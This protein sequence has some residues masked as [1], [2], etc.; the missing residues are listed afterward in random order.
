MTDECAVGQTCQ[1]GLCADTGGSAGAKCVVDAECEGCLVCDGGQC[2][3][4]TPGHTAKAGCATCQPGT[5]DCSCNAGTCNFGYACDTEAN[6]CTFC[7]LGQQIASCPAAGSCDPD[8]PKPMFS[9]TGQCGL[10][11]GACQHTGEDALTAPL[12]VPSLGTCNCALLPGW[13]LSSNQLRTCDEDG[14]GWISDSAALETWKNPGNVAAANCKSA[15][16][17]VGAVDLIAEDG[18]AQQI[19][20]TAVVP[21][22]QISEYIATFVLK[23]VDLNGIPDG[24]LPLVEPNELDQSNKVSAKLP[25]FPDGSPTSTRKAYKAELNPLVKYCVGGEAD[26]NF[27]GAKDATEDE[28]QLRLGSTAAQTVWNR[29]SYFGQL[30]MGRFIEET[31]SPHIKGRWEVRER[32]RDLPASDPAR[33]TVGY[34]PDTASDHWKRCR[35]LTD[36]KYKTWKDTTPVG[37]DFAGAAT[38]SCTPDGQGSYTWGQDLDPSN[39]STW[40]PDTMCRHMGH[41]A[42]FRC[43]LLTTTGAA[44]GT[45]AGLVRRTAAQLAADGWTPNLCT[46]G[47]DSI[48]D[49]VHQASPKVTCTPKTESEATTLAT[50]AGR[51]VWAALPPTRDPGGYVSGCIDECQDWVRADTGLD[52]VVAKTEGEGGGTEGGPAPLL[53]CPL[54]PTEFGLAHCAC[55]NAAGVEPSDGASQCLQS[56]VDGT[57]KCGCADGACRAP[58]PRKP[59]GACGLGQWI[60]DAD[61]VTPK[62]DVPTI[63]GVQAIDENDCNAQ[64]VYV[65]VGGDDVTGAG[66]REA[67]FASVFHA[68]DVAVATPGKRAVMAAAG[69][70]GGTPHTTTGVDEGLVTV[71]GGYVSELSWTG[72]E[73]FA[74]ETCFWDRSWWDE[75]T[76][77]P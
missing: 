45:P 13:Y 37:F 20:V 43:V 9:A 50:T 29:F 41:H 69:T 26:Y 32:N 47:V 42:Q 11:P 57:C 24:A 3:A 66:T 1:D 75:C 4:W 65:T 7:T 55:T 48:V 73:C 61:G 12:V 72:S 34:L 14:D 59:C 60:F 49:G 6:K 19:P 28:H 70:F 16:R 53:S 71:M 8:F 40:K 64:F 21:Q 2:A 27:N 22:A 38:D 58:L 10:C 63:P 31:T 74:T 62:C 54:N 46:Y 44:N 39:A 23:G 68:V 67:P 36:A 18:L 76:L 5:Y 25:N 35:R 52:A 56:A 33:V 77:A 30:Y 51:A 17:W 15:L